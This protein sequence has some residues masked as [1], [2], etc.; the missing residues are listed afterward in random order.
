[1]VYTDLMAPL[2]SIS[3][4][5]HHPLPLN[6]FTTFI[7]ASDMLHI[8]I[9]YHLCRKN[10][11]RTAPFLFQKVSWK[12]FMLGGVQS[13]SGGDDKQRVEGVYPPGLLC[14]FLSYKQ[15]FILPVY[16]NISLFLSHSVSPESLASP[17]PHSQ[18]CCLTVHMCLLAFIF[19]NRFL[20]HV[21]PQ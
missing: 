9:F 1:M 10:T 14:P 12:C 19:F 20:H 21:V 6:Y 2:Y 18:M 11:L 13:Q 8:S 5:K 17:P 15:I 7:P 4:G 16:G 3:D